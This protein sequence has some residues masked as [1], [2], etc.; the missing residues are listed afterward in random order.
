MGV[1]HPVF[2]ANP[3][4]PT[5][6]LHA[7]A[8]TVRR[9]DDSGAADVGRNGTGVH[10]RLTKKPVE[11]IDGI[12]LSARR[13]GHVVDLPRHDADVLLAEGWASW[14]EPAF[15]RRDAPY[16]RRRP[17]ATFAQSRLR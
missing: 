3:E 13:V 11:V 12:D 2:S 8:K 16:R 4:K 7:D 14:V 9:V 17:A 1:G 5:Q 15:W 6:P 10:V